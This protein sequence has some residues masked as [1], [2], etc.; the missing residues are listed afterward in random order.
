MPGGGG[1]TPSDAGGRCDKSAASQPGVRLVILF[2]AVRWEHWKYRAWQGY[3]KEQGWK[4]R[5]LRFDADDTARYTLADL[6]NQLVKLIPP[7]R[8][9]S[10]GDVLEGKNWPNPRSEFQEA[11]PE[12]NWVRWHFDQLV[13]AGLLKKTGDS[14]YCLRKALRKG[15]G[16][17]LDLTQLPAPS[18]VPVGFGWAYP[19][20]VG[21]LRDSFGYGM[22][23]GP[24][25]AN[26]DNAIGRM[27]A[28]AFCPGEKPAG[29]RT[30]L[31]QV[32]DGHA[33][34][35]LLV[36]LRAYARDELAWEEDNTWP[37][38]LRGSDH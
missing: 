26:D 9:F 21:F 6:L 31:E 12:A 30:F 2:Q 14:Q 15:Q 27:L 19:G 33:P 23:F 32:L 10:P 11:N 22:E 13:S 17:T 5:D 24:R 16:L 4:A 3:L 37:M 28:A 1:E 18:T 8:D 7:D 34:A 29:G 36:L 38:W 20:V 35:W 25:G